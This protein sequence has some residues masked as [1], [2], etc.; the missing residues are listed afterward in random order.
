MAYR[1]ASSPQRHSQQS[2]VVYPLGVLSGRASRTAAQPHNPR[3]TCAKRAI[4]V[5]R[6]SRKRQQLKRSQCGSHQEGAR[7]PGQV[8]AAGADNRQPLKR[9]GG[10]ATGRRDDETTWRRGDAEA[11]RQGQQP[12]TTHTCAHQGTRAEHG[13]GRKIISLTVDLEQR[14]GPAPEPRSSYPTRGA[15]MGSAGK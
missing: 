15:K 3:P 4:C 14:H 7:A 5:M 6:A 12:P 11:R 13:K 2:P 10:E 1:V 9:R 8:A